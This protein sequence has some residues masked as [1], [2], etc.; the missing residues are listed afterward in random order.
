M[1]ERSGGTEYGI[2]WDQRDDLDLEDRLT[3]T[4]YLPEDRAVENP[5]RP[6]TFSEYIGQDKVK[7]NLKIYI[8]AARAGRSLW[9]TCCST[10]RRAWARPPWRG[11]WQTSWG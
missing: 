11:L 2:D 1:I 3:D 4:G 5:L 8:E 9:T 6:R 10:A 7:E